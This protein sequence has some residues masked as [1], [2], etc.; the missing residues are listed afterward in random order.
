[1]ADF[2]YITIQNLDSKFGTP[3]YLMYPDVYVKNLRTFLGA[4]KCSYER[5]I[6]GYSFKTNYVPALCKYAK[7]EGCY[8]EV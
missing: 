7:N 8:A 1:M 2:N 3:F 4:F 6:S 5:I